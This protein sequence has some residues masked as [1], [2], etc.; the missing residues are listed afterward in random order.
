MR[1]KALV[2]IFNFYTHQHIKTGKVTFESIKHSSEFL[3]SGEFMK[4][5]T[6]FKIPVK[7]E[8][9]NEVFKKTATYSSSMS[10]DQFL[11]S[12]FIITLRLQLIC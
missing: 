12:F 11:V 5:C 2:E 6:E 10:Y 3:D 8:V 1:V 9:V 7:R 4:F